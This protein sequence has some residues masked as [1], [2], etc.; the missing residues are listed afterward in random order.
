V[1][2]AYGEDLPLALDSVSFNITPGSRIAFVGGSGSGKSTV[3]KLLLGLYEPDQGKITI[4]RTDAS[5][6]AKN[7]LRDVFAYV[8]QDS[9]LFP[10]SIGKNI[11]GAREVDMARLEKAAANA[12]IL[13]FIKSLPDGFDGV[14]SEAADNISGG[15][16][17]RIALARAFYKD[18]PVIL[19]DEA[20]AALDPATE[21][22]ILESLE[23]AASDKTIIMVAH[24]TKAIAAC[25][26]IVVMD[27]GKI[28]AI[29]GHEELL[30][31]NDISRNLY[32]D[33]RQKEEMVVS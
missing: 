3:L 18:A 13:D 28:S 11:A 2:F 17:Q 22:K 26:L 4:S 6:L 33:Q 25:D 8:P 23:G 27:G 31:T 10:E 24:R 5:S 15:Q 30:K 14:L 20:T 12:G 32:E 1:S 9:F 19:F 21:A 16:R 7:S 29:G